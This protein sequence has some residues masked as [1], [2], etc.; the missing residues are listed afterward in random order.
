MGEG[1]GL[2]VCE[3]F[4]KVLLQCCLLL[5]FAVTLME[6]SEGVRASYW[7]PGECSLRN[8]ALCHNNYLFIF[9]T[10]RSG[11]TSIFKAL[12]KIPGVHLCGETGVLP[13]YKDLYEA[14]TGG[15]NSG[16]KLHTTQ[17]LMRLLEDLQQ[18]FGM[19]HPPSD[20]NQVRSPLILGSKEVH[21]P[22][23]MLDFVMR[24][25]PCSRFIFNYR[26]D[27]E[28]QGNSG[29]HKDERTPVEKLARER[30]KMIDAHEKLGDFRTF[31]LPL[32]DLNK[33]KFNELVDWIGFEDCE[34]KKIGH[35]NY[36]NTYRKIKS[37]P[38]L[39]G[40]CNHRGIY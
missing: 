37:W 16:R 28:A 31:L 33:E 21:V 27:L 14:V 4:M 24:M 8:A 32:E 30:Q 12:K 39:Q 19:L 38:H 34:F 6:S 7:C 13:S 2:Q 26:M 35:Y 3:L 1:A 29:F 9:G 25:F 17:Q 22:M 40:N 18:L 15:D 20:D 23:D 11:S 10:G 5:L 36:N